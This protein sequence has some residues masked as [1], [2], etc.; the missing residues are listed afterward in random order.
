MSD[1]ADH[2]P[3][4]ELAVNGKV[5]MYKRLFIGQNDLTGF[6]NGKRIFLA[7]C[8]TDTPH[9]RRVGVAD[10]P[11]RRHSARHGKIRVRHAVD[12]L[13]S[14]DTALRHATSAFQNKKIK[15]NLTEARSLHRGILS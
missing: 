7:L 15:K 6:L 14:S 3:S 11:T 5:I 2:Y 12:T 10:T 8:C 9:P 13:T 4:R 1:D